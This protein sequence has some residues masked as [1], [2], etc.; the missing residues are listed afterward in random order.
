MSISIS[1]VKSAHQIADAGA[2][3]VPQAEVWDVAT[4][5][6][7]RDVSRRVRTTR[8][9]VRTLERRQHSTAGSHSVQLK[10]FETRRE[11]GRGTL[12]G[13][14]LGVALVAGSAFGGV[15]SGAG[16]PPGQEGANYP[17]VGRMQVAR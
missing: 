16:A 2:V 1:P 15:F 8:A 5:P 7:G 3:T 17:E 4:L 13:I 9:E 12:L 6:S 10:I 11:S 14:A